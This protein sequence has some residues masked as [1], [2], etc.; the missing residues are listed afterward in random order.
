VAN[1]ATRIRRASVTE[2][3]GLSDHSMSRPSDPTPSFA[4]KP[5]LGPSFTYLT[6][7]SLFM[8][9][10]NRRDG[11]DAE[12]RRVKVKMLKCRQSRQSSGAICCIDMRSGC[13]VVGEEL[14]GKP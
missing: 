7:M 6:D 12:T 1:T 4:Y 5:S 14:L 2:Q 9:V 8:T 10:M 11:R 3:A 13:L